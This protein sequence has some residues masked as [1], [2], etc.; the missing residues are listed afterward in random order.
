MGELLHIKGKVS[1]EASCI[2][3]HAV[4]VPDKKLKDGSFKIEEG[5]SCVACH[6]AYRE[7]YTR[8]SSDLEDERRD[9]R[10][11]SRTVKEERY[12][13]RD[14]WDPAKRAKVC[15]SC[16]IGNH[17][18][19]KW[20]THAMYAAGHPPLPSV[21]VATFSD[22]M[23]RHWQYLKEKKQLV[24]ELLKVNRAEA[25]FEQTHLVL[26]GGVVSL[27]ET[28]NLLA[29]EADAGSRNQESYPAWPELAQFDCYACHHE[30]KTP[31]WRQRRGY[32]GRPGRPQMH[33]WP[34][35]LVKLALRYVGEDENALQSAMAPLNAAFDSQ[36]FGNPSDIVAK[37]TSVAQW[38][39]KLLQKLETKLKQIQHPVAVQ[40]LRDLCAQ[41]TATTP[42][43]HSARQIAWAFNIIYDEAFPDSAP[44]PAN[45]SEIQKVRAALNEQL[46][47]R[48]PSGTK[49]KIDL[50]QS[51]PA[52][53]NYDPGPFQLAMSALAKLLPQ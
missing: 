28:M 24:Q 19:G 7:W 11:L 32:A 12:G 5:V 14:L 31:S 47:L 13:M 25:A 10:A 21:E 50:S 52:I 16:H 6:G 37:A 3:C 48:L 35:E 15:L 30:L 44:K 27:R 8:H 42:D 1:E 22:A 26:L 20:V 53:N 9:W 49:K 2:S 34:T 18:E 23:P 40:L 46:M 39:D 41:A 33:A 17:N 51:L 43:Y 29:A 36:P 4:Y 38:A 45:D